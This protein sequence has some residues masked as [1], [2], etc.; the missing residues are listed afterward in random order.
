MI[1]TVDIEF[2]R[3]T[4]KLSFT[5]FNEF[6]TAPAYYL[7]YINKDKDDPTDDMIIGKLVHVFSL[8]PE[9][10]EEYACGP[11]VD[12]RT[13][14]GKD[15]MAEFIKNNPGKKIIKYKLYNQ[16]NN[17]AESIRNNPLAM[18][19]LGQSGHCEYKWE[20]EIQ[21]LPFIGFIDKYIPDGDLKAEI[22]TVQDVSRGKIERDF[23]SSGYHIQYGL[24][25]LIKPTKD[26]YY[27]NVEKTEPFLVNTFRASDSYINYGKRVIR[28]K[29]E[30]FKDCM[31]RNT[32]HAGYEAWNGGEIEDLNLP[33]WLKID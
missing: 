10:R 30:D 2:L 21:D 13:N 9:R 12:M 27:I 32:F 29:I 11:E 15:E 19:V 24:Y 20:A 28:Q 14:K 22:K 25:D 33:G 6:C 8:E 3:H 31:A 4:R 23:Y 5:S 7:H 16:A 17:M 1:K 26:N 18:S